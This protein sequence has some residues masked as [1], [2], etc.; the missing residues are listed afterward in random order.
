MNQVGDP[1]SA[2]LFAEDPNLERFRLRAFIDQLQA[3]GELERRSGLGLGAVAA[4]LEGNPKA[5]LFENLKSTPHPLVG[6]VIGTRQRMAMAFGVD[7]RQMAGE[8]C[9]RLDLA[10]QLV[11]VTSE[12]APVHQVVM[13][14]ADIDLIDM[15][16]HLQHA[17]DGGPF[18]SAGVDVTHDPETGRPNVGC[19]R[20]MLRNRD[21]VH[22]GMTGDGRRNHAAALKRCE[23]LPIA[24]ILGSWPTDSFTGAF[25]GTGDELAL[26]SS[27]RAAPL[28]LVKCVTQDL[29]V[30]A[31]AEWVIEGYLDAETDSEAPYGEYLGCYGVAT[32]ALP[33]MHVTAVTRRR[34][35]LFPTVT[36]SG[37][38]LEYT[39]TTTLLTAVQE[40]ATWRKL[41]AAVK[42]PVAVYS[43][44]RASQLEMRIAIRAQ[45]DKEPRAAM[46]AAFEVTFLKNIYVVDADIDIFSDAA[47]TWAM[48]SRFLP[49]RDMVV[50]TDVKLPY[51]EPS[52]WGGAKASKVG[53][54]L[55][56]PVGREG[57]LDVIPAP[58]T[59]PGAR[60]E[61]VRKA[62]EHGPKHFQELMAAIGSDDGRDVTM[63]LDALRKEGVLRRELEGG[64]YLL[65]G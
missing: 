12:Q 23:R 42:Q 5:V 61:S 21:T 63:M 10:P 60:F 34:D 22:I 19:R 4:A 18:I 29:R 44:P 6:N 17:L 62:L 37:P 13:T 56:R 38:T 31:D 27:L 55:T 15:P 51:K 36:I 30:P 48:A 49:H 52:M 64:R 2:R 9:R 33:V 1:Q 41:A 11:E 54:D 45:D 7:H 28:P 8:I 14:G 20:M 59:Y 16:V 40:A 58:P 65:A 46:Q 50:V 39:D 47:M 25:C 35:A 43:P 26:M 32:A 3:A 24:I 57:P 53:F